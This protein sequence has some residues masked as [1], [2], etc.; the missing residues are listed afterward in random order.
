[1][2]SVERTTAGPGHWSEAT[3]VASL[4]DR[5]LDGCA[6]YLPVRS[7]GRIV[8]FE[9]THLNP[10]GIRRMA[11]Q[12]IDVRTTS[13]RTAA[14]GIEHHTIFQRYV[15]VV[16]SQRPWSGADVTYRNG[17]VS[18]IYDIQAWPVGEGFAVTWREVTDRERV[19]D[20]LRLSE[21]RFRA[22]VDQLPDAVSVFEAVRGADGTIDDFRWV[23]CNTYNAQMTG[24]PVEELVG[25]RL[26]EVFPEQ[27]AAGML[28]VY[29]EVVET[30]VSWESPTVWYEDEWGDG[31]RRRRAFDVRASRVGD[32]FVVVSRDVTDLR[33]TTSSLE[34][35]TRSLRDL[36]GLIGHDL[37]NPLTVALGNMALTELHLDALAGQ[38]TDVDAAR[39]TLRKGVAA[40]GRVQGI[41]DD[42]LEMSRIDDP[43]LRT[44]CRV[45]PA[46][47]PLEQALA[48]LALGSE[49]VVEG[50]EGLTVVADGSHLSQVLTNLLTNADKYGAVPITVSGSTHGSTT[51]LVV[52]DSGDGV[53]EEFVPRLFDRFSRAGGNDA[54]GT[55]LGLHLARQL[56]R[57]MGGDLTYE[58][59]ADGTGPSFVVSLAS[60]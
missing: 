27:R 55:G 3:Q 57:A 18:G 30:G 37:K 8:D 17:S 39:A 22:T 33:L 15:E 5:M 47:A 4:L 40:A 7:G 34:E 53:P 52:T 42:L 60:G 10:A 23:Y 48:D 56:C 51:R 9:R 50:V 1:M 29:A 6:I 54:P 38:G 16:E 20:A 25:A 44:E 13:L 32:G 31:T 19:L 43:S 12:G 59:P 11:S 49:V 21:T 14:P 35:S 28:D 26:L 24:Y 58:P 46:A 45:I 36:V 41:L 2:A